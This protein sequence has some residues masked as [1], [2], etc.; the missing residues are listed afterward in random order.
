MRNSKSSLFLMEMIIAVLVFSI[1]SAV[2]VQIFAK[3]Y[4]TSENTQI[5]NSSVTACSSAAE[6]FYGFR[7]DLSKLQREIDVQRTSEAEPGKLSFYYDKDFARTGA[8]D[9]IY[10]MTMETN[11]MDDLM[12]CRIC[13][14]RKSDNWL[15][16]SLNC[17]MYLRETH[18]S[19]AAPEDQPLDEALPGP[20]AEPSDGAQMGGVL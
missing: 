4:I 18:G 15:I 5:L 11:R 9:A 3:A 7:G 6:L 13:M 14:R 10:C 2:C 1:C 19:K 20:G 12:E 8:G 16:Y 17:T